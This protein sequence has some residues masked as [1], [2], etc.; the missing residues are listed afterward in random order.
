[1]FCVCW[2]CSLGVQIEAKYNSKAANM[3]KLVLAK[4]IKAATLPIVAPVVEE[5]VCMCGA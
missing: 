5:K 4:K 1:M 3:Y 2:L